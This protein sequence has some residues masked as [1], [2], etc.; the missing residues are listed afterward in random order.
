MP[1]TIVRFFP[2][3]PAPT[4]KAAH[5]PADGLT[6][7]SPTAV[8]PSAVSPNGTSDEIH[9]TAKDLPWVT[10]EPD[11]GLYYDTIT[12][13]YLTEG[14]LRIVQER[15]RSQP[16]HPQVRRFQERVRAS[17]LTTTRAAPIDHDVG[18]QLIAKELNDPAHDPRPVRAPTEQLVEQLSAQMENVEQALAAQQYDT[19][20][21]RFAVLAHDYN[22]LLAGNP[23]IA[24]D[25]DMARIVA[26]MELLKSRVLTGQAS[27][28]DTTSE[29]TALLEASDS[30]LQRARA[31]LDQHLQ[32]NPHDRA[33]LEQRATVA[34][35]QGD[36]K[37][38]VDDL[39]AAARLDGSAQPRINVY[40][41]HLQERRTELARQRASAEQHGDTYTVAL[42]LKEEIS[43]AKA[44]RDVGAVA[45]L[46]PLLAAAAP[47]FDRAVLLH[48][49]DR[50]LGTLNGQSDS[51]RVLAFGSGLM[52]LR[53]QIVSAH[54]P[55]VIAR[56]QTQCEQLVQ[57]YNQWGSVAD[58]L[59]AHPELLHR[60]ATHQGVATQFAWNGN[61]PHGGTRIA[62]LYESARSA[63]ASG[64]P[65]QVATALTAS[66]HIIRD[67]ELLHKAERSR[68]FLLSLSSPVVAS[69]AV[70]LDVQYSADGGR[71]Y[72]EMYYGTGAT[73][74]PKQLNWGLLARTYQRLAHSSNPAE[75]SLAVRLKAA[76]EFFRTRSDAALMQLPGY[77]E[78]VRLSQTIEQHLATIQQALP[79]VTA[80]SRSTTADALKD[81]DRTITQLGSTDSIA[82]TLLSEA[83]STASG[84]ATMSKDLES[85]GTY[86]AIVAG[87]ATQG[88]HGN[89]WESRHPDRHQAL[90]DLRRFAW[91]HQKTVRDVTPELRSVLDGQITGDRA[92]EIL[93][94]AAQAIR[95]AKQGVLAYGVAQRVLKRADNGAIIGYHRD[96]IARLGE[97]AA[98]IHTD[99]APAN[100][101]ATARTTAIANLRHNVASFRTALLQMR[102]ELRDGGKGWNFG[103]GDYHL[104]TTA[105]DALLA[106]TSRLLQGGSL[107]TGE[108]VIGLDSKQLSDQDLARLSDRFSHLLGCNGNTTI[109]RRLDD[110]HFYNGL[111][112]FTYEAFI[113]A[114]FGVVG[115][116]AGRALA[117]ARVGRMLNHGSKLVRFAGKAAILA[118]ESAGMTAAGVA[119]DTHILG[120][121]LPA[122]FW[123]T[124][125]HLSERVL[126]GMGMLGA[127][128]AG[129]GRV[130]PMIQR[131]MQQQVISTLMRKGYT[132]AYLMGPAGQ[133]LIAKTLKWHLKATMTSLGLTT[134]TNFAA[135][136]AWEWIETNVQLA[137]QGDFAPGKALEMT[138]SG[139][140]MLK[141]LGM[142]P[143][144]H[145]Y[146]AL[147]QPLAKRTAMR[148]LHDALRANPTLAAEYEGLTSA[149]TTALREFE[150]YRDAVEGGRSHDP[151]RFAEVQGK[152]RSA[153]D[154][155]GQFLDR[156]PPQLKSVL[157]DGA[158]D[159][160]TVRD[161]DTAGAAF[162]RVKSVL[163]ERNVYGIVEYRNGRFLFPESR[164]AAVTD[165][166]RASGATVQE[167][168]DGT[169][170]VND[171]IYLSPVRERTTS[172]SGDL[173]RRVADQVV[174]GGRKLIV[175]LAKV[176][177]AVAV[178]W[179]LTTLFGMDSGGMGA[180][181]VF[182]GLKEVNGHDLMGGNGRENLQ[183]T[184]AFKQLCRVL[185]NEY[186]IDVSTW[187]ESR[188]KDLRR[189]L[190]HEDMAQPEL[191]KADGR[192][193][194]HT[195]Q[196]EIDAVVATLAADIAAHSTEETAPS[197]GTSHT[198]ATSHSTIDAYIDQFAQTT[199]GDKRSQR[200]LQSLTAPQRAAVGKTMSDRMR[201]E[202]T[203]LLREHADMDPQSPA[204]WEAWFAD[205]VEGQC[206]DI[207]RD[208]LIEARRNPNRFLENAAPSADTFPDRLATAPNYRNVKID[209]DLGSGRF[210]DLSGEPK[211]LED[212]LRN[213]EDVLD[214]PPTDGQSVIV[215]Y[216]MDSTGEIRVGAP[217]NFVVHHSS[218]FGPTVPVK[219]VGEMVVVFAAD[220]SGRLRGQVQQVNAISGHFRPSPETALPLILGAM[221][222]YQIPRTPDFFVDAN[223]R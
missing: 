85:G 152:L 46:T 208:I 63:L 70:P 23:H 145:L 99:H 178:D 212:F 186:D 215:I 193:N 157:G 200:I 130:G 52:N 209:T 20:T 106:E 115:A 213:P 51:D 11:T 116:V 146:G 15:V 220:A 131:K 101:A 196:A 118:A 112:D 147:M 181:A 217:E 41:A 189:R 7:P 119:A 31:Q 167:G 185:K 68:Q 14:Q 4:G 78:R 65:H 222:L 184:A 210:K 111:R 206:L 132:P 59:E 88:M 128:H 108:S 53:A 54:E 6:K 37:A 16:Q 138:M 97:E 207:G 214:Q 87:I 136:S 162:E 137:K 166:L 42:C 172:G 29:R 75:Q 149:T 27:V 129:L 124:V 57:L 165:A 117:V 153:L 187:S 134:A 139:G 160:Q 62:A 12:G 61:V 164:R 171:A 156:A 221:E 179:M 174:A 110:M 67:V 163:G 17:R 56:L 25:P 76:V 10:Y 104:S 223:I 84:L 192:R 143:A 173:G 72:G 86:A 93:Q 199:L 90:R 194:G 50:L 13:S 202:T 55:A 135:F 95:A 81:I 69:G 141:R 43:I 155:R 121:E 198:T 142:I 5:P 40:L 188:Q 71:T 148:Q 125:G 105:V 100:D 120:H 2:T 140:A 102:T 34:D 177:A 96:A 66:T 195:T 47:A 216:A 133:Q 91:Q 38:A 94:R 176:G 32:K 197:A 113:M 21:A 26:R 8:T 74:D 73:L 150:A 205:L 170:V 154:A 92:R 35:A 45:A 169:L 77:I 123:N 60:V 36:Y 218:L 182:G 9:L 64:D 49:V 144:F 48:E 58:T 109:R 126:M 3:A 80:A 122:G 22:T 82:R 114:P 180:M 24:A 1:P 190:T 151:A 107:P 79:Y 159:R 89:A 219:G 191:K 211:L 201:L 44:V 168:A 98:L 204:Q 203:R 103:A 39:Q 83:E 161:V 28:T 127:F 158:R 175:P 33:A 30:S 19:A 18:A 183:A